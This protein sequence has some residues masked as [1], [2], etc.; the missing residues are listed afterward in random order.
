MDE[1]YYT[2]LYYYF[3]DDRT[4]TLPVR[5]KVLNNIMKYLTMISRDT[6][7]ADISQEE[8]KYQLSIKIFQLQ[9]NDSALFKQFTSNIT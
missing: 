4:I 1:W 7:S 3:K 5:I 9:I 2:Y 6:S 8:I